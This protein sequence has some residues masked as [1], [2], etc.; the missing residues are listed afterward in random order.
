[1]TSDT[2]EEEWNIDVQL[3]G[4]K[5]ENELEEIPG[6]VAASTDGYVIFLYVKKKKF[7]TKDFILEMIQKC[8]PEF[9]T[10]FPKKFVKVV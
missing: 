10:L 4:S 3:F 9:F 7:V 1:M 6:I 5:Y 8:I 2:D